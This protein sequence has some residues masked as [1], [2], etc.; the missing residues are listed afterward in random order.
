M[1]TTIKFKENAD[2]T[3]LKSIKVSSDQFHEMS[4]TQQ[5]MV[6]IRQ[7]VLNTVDKT[8]PDYADKLVIEDLEATANKIRLHFV[9][10]RQYMLKDEDLADNGDYC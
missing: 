8:V 9:D 3:K 2:Q 5:I 7:L 1:Q 10:M 6:D 4:D